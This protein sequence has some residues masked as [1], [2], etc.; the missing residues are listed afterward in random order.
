MKR[1]HF[2]RFFLYYKDCQ[3]NGS[4][5]IFFLSLTDRLAITILPFSDKKTNR[6]VGLSALL[7]GFGTL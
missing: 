2:G 6:K 5:F 7:T 4:R 3:V 1:I